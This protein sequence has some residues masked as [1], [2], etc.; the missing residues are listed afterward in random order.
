MNPRN[1]KG[2]MATEEKKI[3]PIIF[4]DAQWEILKPLRLKWTE[5][6]P[7]MEEIETEKNRLK[8][9][10]KMLEAQTSYWKSKFWDKVEEMFPHTKGIGLAFCGGE[11]DPNISG[12]NPKDE[13]GPPRITQSDRLGDLKKLLDGLPSHLL[14]DMPEDLKKSLTSV[15]VI[16]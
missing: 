4:T 15:G 5:N 3:D 7:R 12:R 16:G 6:Y 14:N 11:G 2:T 8:K 1:L 10:E 9:E 13:K